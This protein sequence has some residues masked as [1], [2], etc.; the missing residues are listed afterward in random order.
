M[1]R[2]VCFRQSQNDRESAERAAV[3]HYYQPPGREGTDHYSKQKSQTYIYICALKTLLQGEIL[4]GRS[5][6]PEGPCGDD[7]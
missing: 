6:N 2:W 1:C 7:S 5:K 3:G 4:R